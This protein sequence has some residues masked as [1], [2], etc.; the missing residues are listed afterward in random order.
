MASGYDNHGEPVGV[1]IVIGV[2]QSFGFIERQ[3]IGVAIGVAQW[4]SLKKRIAQCE[5]VT[6]SLMNHAVTN[7]HR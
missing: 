4:L 1:A 6:I 7:A 3:F 5:R 2:A